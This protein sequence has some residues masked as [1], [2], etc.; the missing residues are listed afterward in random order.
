MFAIHNYRLQRLFK[1]AISKGTTPLSYLL[2]NGMWGSILTLLSA[3]T[4]TKLPI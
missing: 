4:N 1:G 3:M 2:V